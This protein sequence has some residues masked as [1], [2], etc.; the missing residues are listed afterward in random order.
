M[1]EGEDH[2]S[3][4]YED[5]VALVEDAGQALKEGLLVFDFDAQ[6]LQLLEATAHADVGDDFSRFGCVLRLEVRVPAGQGQPQPDVEK[7]SQFGIGDVAAIGRVG[8]D[9]VHRA[10]W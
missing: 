5:A 1:V 2:Q 10:I 6:L 3:F 4:V 9:R 8:D 7:V